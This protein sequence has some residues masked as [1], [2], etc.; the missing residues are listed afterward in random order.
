M[1]HEEA[2]DGVKPLPMRVALPKACI[3]PCKIT[4]RYS[5]SPAA[6][7]RSTGYPD[8][9]N[10]HVPLV[11]PLDVELTGNNVAVTAGAEQQ[12]EVAPDVWTAVEGGLGQ[13]ASPRTRE[14]AAAQATT[15][16]AL[17]LNGE[18]S[19]DAAVVVERAWIQTCLTRSPGGVRQDRAV[20]Q[21][22]TRRHELEITLP[23]GAARDQV[24]VQLNGAPV[25]PRTRAERVL[26]VP[27]PADV[28]PPRYV[29]GLQY[30]FPDWRAGHA[31]AG[32]RF[33]GAGAMKF[34]AFRAW[35]TTPGSA[36]PIGNF[37]SPPEEH[38][39]VSPRELT[40]E[41]A[42][43][44]NRFYFGR[45]PVLSQAD[46][47]KWVGLRNPGSTP[48]P[49][50]MNA[51]LFSSLGRI[52]TYEIVTA[53]RSTIVF[54]SSGIALLAGLLLIYVRTARHPVVLLVATAILAVLTA[55]YPELALMAAQASA[56]GLALVL[57]RGVLAATD[58]GQPT[59]GP[60]R[61]LRAIPPVLP[62]PRHS[63]PP[64]PV[65]ASGSS[66]ATIIPMPPEAAT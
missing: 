46:L 13:A 8:D 63:E 47:E 7:T 64:V 15:E 36:V 52:G 4:A 21:L 60:R 18:S 54:L 10:I 32:Y 11:M 61:S 28:E 9:G 34:A 5:L 19:G 22:T 43:G 29:L 12:V 40:G 17:K 51:Y 66:T 45:Q 26:I 27:L 38:L 16:I 35:A 48:A 20:L 53:G 41:F 37:S 25:T 31:L 62:M 49:A 24:S 23:E 44:W 39:I 42:W 55:I 59:A 50:G 14:F 58:R 2:D 65:A 30:H 56:V 57:L 3:G 33:A 1:W 6:A